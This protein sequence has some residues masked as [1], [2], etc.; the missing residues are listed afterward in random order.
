MKVIIDRD[1]CIGDGICENVCPEVFEVR[2]DGL[3]YVLSF[4]E[5]PELIEKIEEAIDE[6]PTSAISMEEEGEEGEEAEGIAEEA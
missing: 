6:C 5:T 2:D 1:E 3:A 4:E